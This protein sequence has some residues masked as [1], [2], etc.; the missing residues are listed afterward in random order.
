[1]RQIECYLKQEYVGR[2]GG[3]SIIRSQV[4]YT[5]GSIGEVTEMY[6]PHI[7][8]ATRIESS[9]ASLLNPYKE[10]SCTLES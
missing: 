5:D 7:M 2:S 8:P 10:E 9:I 4:L 6:E 1:M 3:M